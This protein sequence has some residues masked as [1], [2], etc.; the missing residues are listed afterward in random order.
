M[1]SYPDRPVGYDGSVVGP[2]HHHLRVAELVDHRLL[3]MKGPLRAHQL[4]KRFAFQYLDTHLSL[5]S[6]RP[7]YTPLAVSSLSTTGCR[8]A[9]CSTAA[10][11][12]PPLPRVRQTPPHSP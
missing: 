1:Y 2:H 10:G 3:P 4:P 6:L 5:L 12:R 9:H 11:R 7:E 8:A